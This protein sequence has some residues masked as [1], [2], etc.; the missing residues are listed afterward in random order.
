MITGIVQFYA[1]LEMLQRPREVALK[2]Q[3]FADFVVSQEDIECLSRVLGGCQ[4]LL[5][6]LGRGRKVTLYEVGVGHSPEHAR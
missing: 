6:D 3:R 2:D 5:R 1:V 4:R